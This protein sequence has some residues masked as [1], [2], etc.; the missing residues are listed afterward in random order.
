[1]SSVDE[2]RKDLDIE[3]EQWPS[4]LDE[5][6]REHQAQSITVEI[7][8][9]TG[10]LVQAK[11]GRLLAIEIDDAECLYIELE[12]TLHGS[13]THVIPSPVRIRLQQQ[14]GYEELAISSADGRETVLLA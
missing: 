13:A 8:T 7:R 14:G 6:V 1:M 9:A 12:E 10:K 5:F 3:T 4:F 11:T 2:N